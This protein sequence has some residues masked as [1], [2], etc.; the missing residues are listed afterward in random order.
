MIYGK[1][2]ND[3]PEHNTQI[4][5]YYEECNGKR[6]RRVVWQCP[7]YTTWFNMLTRCYNKIELDRHPTYEQK[8]VC[9]EWLIFSNFKM[10]MESQDWEGKQLDKDIL[11][12]GNLEYCPEKCV[13]VSQE[14]NKFILEKTKIRDLP[15]GVTFHKKK[16]KYISTIS[17]GRNRDI[18]HLGTF[19][20][21]LLAHLAWATEKL[22]LALIVAEKEEDERVALSLI[23]K[24]AKIYEAAKE[25]VKGGSSEK[26]VF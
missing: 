19:T 20:D 4:V 9:K 18:K 17:C 1:A 24:Y 2:I 3:L 14:V 8:F 15:L 10:W 22:Q 6:K 21:P 7:Y 5:E 26:A 12:P 13:F 25:N 11:F 16:M 23:D